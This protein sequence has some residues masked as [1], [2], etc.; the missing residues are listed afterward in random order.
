MRKT[1]ETSIESRAKLD[2]K[3]TGVFNSYEY[4]DNGKFIGG[5]QIYKPGRQRNVWKCPVWDICESRNDCAINMGDYQLCGVD[6]PEMLKYLNEI[7]PIP[8][9]D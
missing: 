7:D 6:D 3:I 4:D 2:Q 1:K 8:E 5:T 9:G